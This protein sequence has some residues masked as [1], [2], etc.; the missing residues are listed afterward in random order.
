MLF[1][2]SCELCQV[3]RIWTD[4]PDAFIKSVCGHYRGCKAKIVEEDVESA[5]LRP[6]RAGTEV[7]QVDSTEALLSPLS[8]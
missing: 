8:S 2:V 1:C 3:S 7:N 4:L 5:A 6:K